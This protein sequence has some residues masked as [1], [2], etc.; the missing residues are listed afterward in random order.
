MRWSRCLIAVLC[1]ALIAS[2]AWAQVPR[3]NGNALVTWAVPTGFDAALIFGWDLRICKE[4][5]CT[6]TAPALKRTPAG[7]L[8]SKVFDLAPLADGTWFISCRVLHVNGN[9]SPF[10]PPTEFVLDT[11]APP[12]PP[13]PAITPAPFSLVP[14]PPSLLLGG[15]AHA[16]RLARIDQLRDTTLDGSH[17]AD[18]PALPISEPPGGWPSPLPPSSP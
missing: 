17:A 2:P 11:T 5:A 15:S 8:S 18:P 6:P 1:Y 13:A 10:S 3:V 14:I 7:P 4:A 16:A 12:A 9:A